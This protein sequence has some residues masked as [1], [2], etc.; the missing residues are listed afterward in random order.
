MANEKLITFEDKTYR[1][2][3]PDGLA[4]N[5]GDQ[6]RITGVAV[7]VPRTKVAPPNER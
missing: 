3:S 7:P 4:D 1:T 6:S 2:T 5:A